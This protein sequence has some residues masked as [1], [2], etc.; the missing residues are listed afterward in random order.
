MEAEIEQQQKAKAD[1]EA[2][3]AV[4]RKTYTTEIIASIQ[5]LKH[6]KTLTDAKVAFLSLRQRI[7]EDNHTIIE[8]YNR[9]SKRYREAKSS[10]LMDISTNLQV[11][12]NE[13]EKEKYLDG[14]PEISKVKSALDTLDS[15]S[16][17]LAESMKTVDQVLFGLKV[18]IDTEKL[19]L[20]L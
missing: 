8:N 12:L 16:K 9:L 13:R 4:Q 14:L 3:F 10:K 2:K 5:L 15:Q 11:R 20:G 6:I 1:I 19:L 17:F 18:R 7:L